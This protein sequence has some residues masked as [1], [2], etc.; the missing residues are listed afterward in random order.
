MVNSRISKREA[1]LTTFAEATVVR[2]SFNEG[3]SPALTWNVVNRGKPRPYFTKSMTAYS[4][5][6]RKVTSVASSAAA[7]SLTTAAS[8]PA[9]YALADA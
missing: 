9:T 3:G 4:V 6:C 2:P 8:S 5:S 7:K 1:G